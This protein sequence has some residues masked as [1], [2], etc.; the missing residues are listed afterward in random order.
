MPL[1]QEN[2]QSVI[3]Y[4]QYLRKKSS[5]NQNVTKKLQ[6]VKAIVSLVLV[7]A[8]K[9]VG[10]VPVHLQCHVR[11]ISEQDQFFLNWST[12]YSHNYRIQLTACEIKLVSL[13]FWKCYKMWL[14]D[15]HIRRYDITGW[16]VPQYFLIGSAQILWVAPEDSGRFN[17]PTPVASPVIILKTFMVS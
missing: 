14:K 9:L 10:L 7:R 5:E 13:A 11:H 2:P 8:L 1:H 6:T 3:A 4:W 16:G 15:K 12:G 17:P